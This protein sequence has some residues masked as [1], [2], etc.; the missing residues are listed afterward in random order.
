[1]ESITLNNIKYKLHPVFDL[2]GADI[3]GNVISFITRLPPICDKNGDFLAKSH[4]NK[5]KRYK[6]LIF[7]WEIYNGK[8]PRNMTVNRKDRDETNN[9]VDNL[10]LVKRVVKKRLSPEEREE[11]NR[12][13]TERWRKTVWDCPDCG[14]RTTNNASR[15]HKRACKHSNNPFTTDETRRKHNANMRWQNRKYTCEW[16]NNVYSN[17]YRYIHR[18]I[19]KNRNME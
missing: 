9:C 8:K 11:R 3:N 10:I 13:C 5:K 7:I 15:Y 14:F 19:C 12:A 18:K 2:F 1:M 4:D 6:V 16:C 17:S